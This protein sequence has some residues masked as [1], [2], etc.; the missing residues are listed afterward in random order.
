MPHSQ[1]LPTGRAPTGGFLI[2]RVLNHGLCVGCGLCAG[3][4]PC[5]LQMTVTVRGEYQP[6]LRSGHNW[7]DIPDAVGRVCPFSG[8]GENEDALGQREFA[9]QR[10]VQHSPQLGYFLRTEAAW[11]TDDA[12]RVASSAGGLGTWLASHLLKNGIVDGV[13]CVTSAPEGSAGALFEYRILRRVDDLAGS[14]KSKYYPVEMSGVLAELS[15]SEGRFAV[16]ALPCFAKGLRLA[17]Q[18]GLIPRD[19]IHCI[20]GLFCGHL[21]TRQFAHYLIRSCGFHERDT[22]AID[23]RKKVLSARASEYAFE[24]TVRTLDGNLRVNSVRMRDVPLGNWGLNAFMLKACECCDDVVAE[25]ADI[26]M[27]D[28]WLPEFV[29]DGRGTNLLIARRADLAA[30]IDTGVASG[31]IAVRSVAPTA[32]VTSQD[33]AFR[34]RRQ[35]LSYRLHLAQTCGEWR[36]AKRVEPDDRSLKI[37]S[38]LIQRLRLRIAE[39]SKTAFQRHQDRATLRPFSRSMA[40]LLFAHNFLYRLRKVLVRLFVRR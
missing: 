33:G 16:V 28:A 17:I 5:S 8:V 31:E 11:V 20:I 23:F 22:L 40:L 13:C 39:R 25:L 21:K 3:L 26:S 30:I 32:I 35:A 7:D 29:Q 12:A 37:Y 36:P 15:R 2:E 27:G 6:M 19:K 1:P 9:A 24:A 34:Q 4:Q 18:A 14:R 38:K 10:G